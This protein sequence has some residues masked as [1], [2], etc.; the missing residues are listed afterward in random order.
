M[1][2]VYNRSKTSINI[3]TYSFILVVI[4]I[5][6]NLKISRI[7]AQ[8]ADIK[9]DHNGSQTLVQTSLSVCDKQLLK[10]CPPIPPSAMQ[11]AKDDLDSCIKKNKEQFSSSC[12][13]K[14][15]NFSKN[16]VEKKCKKLLQTYCKQNSLISKKRKCYFG[17]A[18]NI[19]Y[20]CRLFFEGSFSYDR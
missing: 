10:L 19:G 17:I 8:T 13:S 12:I 16:S 4:L 20:E 9:I 3:K 7:V 11:N 15:K 18:Q 14:I 1:K 5:L 2:E 6:L